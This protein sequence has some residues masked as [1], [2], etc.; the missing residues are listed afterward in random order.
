[1]LGYPD[2]TGSGSPD[3]P[4]PL[5]NSSLQTLN[6]MGLEGQGPSGPSCSCSN[7]LSLQTL[8]TLRKE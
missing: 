8:V 6:T 3:V 4:F 5:V 2:L 1:M 7:G